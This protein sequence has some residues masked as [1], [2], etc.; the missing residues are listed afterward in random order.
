LVIPLRNYAFDLI[1]FVAPALGR[2]CLRYPKSC[3]GLTGKQVIKARMAFL[4]EKG[5]VS[6]DISAAP[7]RSGR[8]YYGNEPK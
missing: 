8:E 6:W 7:R 1:L 5:C 2:F 3:D 4:E